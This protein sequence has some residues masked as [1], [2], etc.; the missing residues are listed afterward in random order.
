MPAAPEFKPPDWLEGHEWRVVASKVDALAKR[1]DRRT[2]FLCGST[3][4]DDEVW[5]LL[6]RVI[7]LAIDG[8]T[9]R[10]RLASR[11]TND[12]GKSPDELQAIVSWHEVADEQYRRLG[13]GCRRDAASG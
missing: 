2:V 7:C 10:R 6:S 3:A 4:N 1:A 11:T 8:Q 12:F 9:L 5:H 13:A